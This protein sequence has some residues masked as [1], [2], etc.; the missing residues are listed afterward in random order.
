MNEENFESA[1]AI[2]TAA[3]DAVYEWLK[4]NYSY[5]QDTRYQTR[6]KGTGPRLCGKEKSVI[7]P[8]FIIYDKFRGKRAIDVKYKT[9]AYKINGGRHFTVDDYKFDNYMKC[10]EL[11][12]LDGL[13]IIFK[14]ENDMYFY[15]HTD[16]GPLHRFANT[17]GN[18]AYLFEL[19]SKR[20]RR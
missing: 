11:M 20:I 19:D 12:G 6:D 16:R 14:F 2:G 8:D 7:L 15:D 5:V 1:L 9:S 17:Y 4:Q 18:G 3:E 13:I 10:V